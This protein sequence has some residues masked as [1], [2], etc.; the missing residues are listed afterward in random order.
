M[1]NDVWLTSILISLLNLVCGLSVVL[2]FRHRHFQ[3]ILV[4]SQKKYFA[5]T[6]LLGCLK[7]KKITGSEVPNG[8]LE[9]VIA[10]F[11]GSAPEEG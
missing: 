3:I 7:M 6:E 10:I 8:R 1:E 4:I 9:A 11:Q 2:Q 5:L